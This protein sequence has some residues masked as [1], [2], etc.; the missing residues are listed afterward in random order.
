MS[1]QAPAFTQYQIQVDSGANVSVTNNESLLINF[2]HIKRHALSG[3]TA[4]QPALFATGIGY[5]PWRAESGETILVK[6][7]YS[8]AAAD[9]I[10]SPN[11]V[12]INHITDYC[13]WSQHSDVDS[14]QGIIKLHHRSNKPDVCFSLSSFN[15]LWYS[16][17]TGHTDYIHLQSNADA[18]PADIVHRLTSGA[19]HELFHHRLV[20]PGQTTTQN[21]HLHLDDMP[22]LR[23]NCFYNCAS[24]TI[25]KITRRHLPHNYHQLACQ[26][27]SNP[28]PVG[29]AVIPPKPPDDPLPSTT[30]QKSA[31]IR[32]IPPDVSETLSNQDDDILPGQ[33]FHIDMGFMRGSDF[34]G[35]AED[36]RIITSIDG[37]NSYLLII[38]RKTR[39]TWVF[40]TKSKAPQPDLI[41][42]FLSLH[43]NKTTARRIIRSDQGGELYNSTVFQRAVEAADFLLH[44]TATDAPFQNGM[45]ERPNRT[46]AT[47]VRC[48]LHAA[49]RGPEFWSW[50]LLHS[51]YVKNRLPHRSTGLTPFLAYRGKKPSAKML[52]IWGCRVIVR[53]PGKRPAKLD[54]HTATGIFLGFTGTD[55]NIY[56]RD[57]TTG[58]IKI[59]THVT[60]DEAGMTIPP[61]DLPPYAIALQ[62]AGYTCT[63][64]DDSQPSIDDTRT[65]DAPTPADSDT[66]QVQLLSSSAI[67]PTRA[68]NQAA[69]YDLYS[70]RCIVIPPHSRHRVPT[71]IAI[72]PPSSTYAQILPRSGMAAKHLID[73]VAGTIDPDF[74]GNIEVVLHNHSANPFTVNIGDR[75][76]QMVFY[77]IASPTVTTVHSLDATTRGANGFGSTG[78]TIALVDNDI[79]V[80]PNKIAEAPAVAIAALLPTVSHLEESAPNILDQPSKSPYQE[81]AEIADEIYKRDGIKPYDIWMS[82]DPFEN[83]LTVQLPVRGNHPTLGMSFQECEIR[84]RLRLQGMEKST[85]G[86]RIAKWRSTLRNAVLISINNDSIRTH[87]ELQLAIRNARQTQAFQISCVFA[88]DNVHGV[89]PMDGHL[90]IYHDQLS[91]FAQHVYAAEKEH[92]AQL[93]KQQEGPGPPNGDTIRVITDAPPTEPQDPEMGKFFKLKQLK[94]RDD[95]PIWQ[96]ARYKQLDQYE[97]QGMFSDPL[98]LPMDCSASFMLWTF[99]FKMDGTKKARMVC[100][101]ARNRTAT[102]LGHTYANSLNAPSERLYW[103][104]TA[105]QGLI[106]VGADVSNAFAE[107]PPPQAP[108]YMYIDEAFRDWWTNHKGRPPIPKECNV[109]QVCKAIQGHPESPR[110]WEKHIDLI[111]RD[112]GF[113]PTRHEPCL[114][115]GSVDNNMVLFLRQV[116]DFSVSPISEE[117]CGKL[118]A[119]INSKMTMAVK[120]L[121]VITRF[122]GMDV[123][124]TK[125][126]IK[127]GCDKI[128]SK[129]ASLT[130]VDSY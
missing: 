37:F 60:F 22:K 29:T 102:S 93:H 123:Y 101:G 28:D 90:N 36:G 24:C 31:E 67:P 11:N 17:H 61:A 81:A 12:V 62:K 6:C 76:A 33:V 50:A 45:A 78:K 66:L 100:D 18:A 8:A 34:T 124:Q 79:S 109:V 20:H 82:H 121:G 91:A 43:G 30:E 7:Y 80:E 53:L 59:A 117:L 52:R 73:T 99:V 32:P 112:M 120:N 105:M 87:S 77:Y 3:V 14:G 122:N 10:V 5:L 85:P 25:A 1:V 69:G 108:L 35:K 111:L 63:S 128:P 9:T 114:Y 118:I 4:D 44:P 127:L 129:D 115:R 56:Y 15:G 41:K 55:H 57:D 16:T 27:A 21:I 89:H 92:R 42:R 54:N 70:A 48:I 23:G 110:L 96:Q 98:A 83:H 84:G 130:W 94:D 71:D 104:L 51:V 49:G 74:T 95:W 40:L 19:L 113:T 125:H 46:L 47:M 116:D 126:Y 26:A 107:A 106:A 64:H 2:K 119:H 88:T 38:D 68:T 72:T 75:I 86:A 58:R 13:G 97:A 39:Y 103:A 65:P